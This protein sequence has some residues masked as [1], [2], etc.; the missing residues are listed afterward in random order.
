[1][2]IL[3]NMS[4]AELDYYTKQPT[5]RALH[6]K[7]MKDGIYI[8][9]GDKAAAA[10]YVKSREARTA[11]ASDGSG[12]KVEISK[13]AYALKDKQ[14][15]LPAKEAEISLDV[16]KTTDGK[17]FVLHFDNSP[18]L[19]RMLKQGYFEVDGKR[20]AIS[21]DMKKEL[22]AK[23]KML[24]EAQEQTAMRNMLEHNAAVAQQQGESMQKE[25]QKQARLMLT[26]SR[27][28]HGRKVSMADEKELLEASPDLYSM[29]KS[30]AILEKNRHRKDDEEDERISKKNDADREWEQSPS[31]IEIPEPAPIPEYSVDMEV[32]ADGA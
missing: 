8:P 25:G 7:I 13:E 20:I 26:V 17:G 23:D 22:L 4:K 30:A 1:M 10:A 31:S 14:E 5:A 29:A 3:A 12:D 16:R 24:R 27:I 19:H 18:L 21:D 2:R 11:S 9:E 32:A 15:A 28:M 6:G